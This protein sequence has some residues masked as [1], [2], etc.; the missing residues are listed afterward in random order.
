MKGFSNRL[1]FNAIRIFD[2]LFFSPTGTW[3]LS[4]FERHFVLKLKKKDKIY[5]DIQLSGF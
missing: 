4:S 5:F 2:T 3:A 1:Q